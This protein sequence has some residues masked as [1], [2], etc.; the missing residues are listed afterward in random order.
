MGGKGDMMEM[1]K[2]GGRG[3]ML[4]ERRREGQVVLKTTYRL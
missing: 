4:G 1:E 3:G 2:E